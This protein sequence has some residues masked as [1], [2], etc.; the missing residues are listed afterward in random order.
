MKK[1]LLINGVSCR[2]IS[3]KKYYSKYLQV[4]SILQAHSDES[5]GRCTVLNHNMDFEYK[6]EL[7]LKEPLP[8]A[9][10]ALESTGKTYIN[11]RLTKRDTIQNKIFGSVDI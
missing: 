7:E 3:C 6:Y 8:R 2:H 4:L 9:K 10:G 5:S 1:T 11:T